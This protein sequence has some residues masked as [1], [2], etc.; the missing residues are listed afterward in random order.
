MSYFKEYR[1]TDKIRN[2]SR[3]SLRL[4]FWFRKFHASSFFFAKFFYKTMFW[5]V[6]KRHGMEIGIRTKIGKGLYIGHP[7]NCTINSGTIIGDNCNIHKNCLIGQENRGSRKGTPTLGNCVWVGA[8]AVIVGNINIGD[9]VL[10]SLNSFVNQDIPSHSIVFG[11]PC[12]IK[13][14]DNA[15]EYYI[16]NRV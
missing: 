15:T 9:D 11:N 13:H 4:L 1:K 2:T 5:L 7:F 12:I 3:Y 16:N 8:N 10:I 14:R 6:S